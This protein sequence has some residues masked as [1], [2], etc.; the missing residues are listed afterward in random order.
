MMRSI[1][2]SGFNFTL[3][4]ANPW[5]EAIKVTAAR[6]KRRIIVVLLNS[7]SPQRPQSRHHDRSGNGIRGGHDF[8]GK[9]LDVGLKCASASPISVAVRN[10][11]LPEAW[12]KASLRK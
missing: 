5:T 11:R 3:L 12:H 1:D 6:K 7:R 10:V 9:D 4:L 8:A 2:C